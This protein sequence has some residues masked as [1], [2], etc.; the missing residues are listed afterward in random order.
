MTYDLK[1]SSHDNGSFKLHN[2]APTFVTFFLKV[3]FNPNVGDGFSSSK[4]IRKQ[5][6]FLL[7]K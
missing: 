7:F 1:N 5:K 6:L 2:N 3:R 4:Y